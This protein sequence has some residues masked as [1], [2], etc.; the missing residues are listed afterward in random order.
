MP[1]HDA[2]SYDL[3]ARVFNGQKE[4]LTR[5]DILDNIT[6]YWLTKTGI[7]SARFYWETFQI[8]KG[9]LFDPRRQKNNS[10]PIDFF[11]PA[12]PLETV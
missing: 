5:D 11:P 9:S 10:R 6:L 2:R 12:T 3:I 7:T 4:G 1:D 8:A